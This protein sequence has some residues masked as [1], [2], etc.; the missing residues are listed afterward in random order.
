M[1][2]KIKEIMDFWFGD[3]EKDGIPAEEKQKMWWGKDENIDKFIKEN[4]E[5]YLRKAAD[6]EL[7]QWLAHPEGTLAVII[8]LDQFSRNMYRKP[9]VRFHTMKWRYRSQRPV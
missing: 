6:G 5:E 1:D 2:N 7:G 3:L 4:Y 8:L 9:P